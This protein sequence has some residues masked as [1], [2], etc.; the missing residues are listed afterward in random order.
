MKKTKVLFVVV[1]FHRGGAERFA[2]ELDKAIN[3]NIFDVS[4][5]CIQKENFTFANGYKRYYDKKHT[6]LGTSIVYSDNF[7]NPIEERP[8]LLRRLIRKFIPISGEI[9]KSEIYKYFDSFD[10]IHWMGEYTYIHTVPDFIRKKSLIQPMSAKFQNS[11]IYDSF[12]HELHYNFCSLFNA[13]EVAYEFSQFK[14]YHYIVVPLMLEIKT[15]ENQWKYSNSK[16]KKIGIFTRLDKYKPLDPF[17]YSFQLLLDHIPDC[18]LHVF[19][20][21]D[22]VAEGMIESLKRLGLTDKV[23]FRGHQED[24]VKTALEENLNLSWFQGYN[25][26]RPAGYAGIDICTTGLPLVCWDF[27]EKPKKAGNP[28]YPHFKNLNQFVSFSLEILRDKDKAEKLSG[29]Q[30]SETIKSRDIATYMPIIENEYMRIVK[31]S[32]HLP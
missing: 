17:F 7:R 27:H 32:E 2:Y 13:D 20:N 24:I 5:F 10:I 15:R 8:N 28:I 31:L 19:G 6:D 23:F 14:N 4:I 9:W 29:I 18:E 3:K 16:I 22:P 21:G 26:D 12:N 25:N 11:K 30:F 1:G